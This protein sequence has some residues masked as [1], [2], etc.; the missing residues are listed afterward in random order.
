[1]PGNTVGIDPL[2]NIILSATTVSTV[3]S[4]LVTSIVFLSTN[5]PN[6]SIFLT[7]LLSNKNWIPA[8]N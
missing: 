6:P 2:A 1:M 3:P 7:P 8:T 5:L 4:A